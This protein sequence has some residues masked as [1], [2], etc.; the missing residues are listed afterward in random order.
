MNYKRI[1]GK[2][3]KIP[4]GQADIAWLENKSINDLCQII[5]LK[6]RSIPDCKEK[7][8]QMLNGIKI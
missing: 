6:S 1:N 8:V 2:M 5:A 7:L 4:H 3:V